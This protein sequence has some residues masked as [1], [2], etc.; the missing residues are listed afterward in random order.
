M[1]LAPGTSLGPY[2]IVDTIGAGGMGEVYRARDTRL[3]RQVAI[4]VLPDSL[5]RDPDGLARFQREAKAVAALSHANILALHDVGTEAGVTYV[6]MELLEGE[7]LRERVQHGPVPLRKAIEIGIQIARGLA[8]AH[9]KGLVH[10]DLKP[11]NVFLLSD[12]QVKVLDFGLAKTFDSSPGASN[13][14][15]RA[16]VTDPGTVLGTVGYMAPEQIRGQAIDARADLFALGAVLFEMISGKRAFHRETGAETMTAILREDP[17]E[18]TGS[19]IAQAPAV[20]RIIRHCLEKNPAER[21]QTARDVAFALEALSGSATSTTAREA[22]RDVPIDRPRSR[23]P[24]WLMAAA[25]LMVVGIV[26]A[27]LTGFVTI[28]RSRAVGSDAA[29]LRYQPVT[30]DEGFV[31]AARFARDGRTLVYSAEWENQPHDIFVTSM[32]SPDRRALGYRGADLLA[33]APDGALAILLDSTIPSGNPYFRRGTVARASLNGSAPKKELDFVVFADFD[34][35]GSLAV[36]RWSGQAGFRPRFEWP[37]GHTVFEESFVTGGGGTPLPAPR[38][39]PDGQHAAF[40]QFSAESMSVKI[41]DRSGRVVAESKS[42]ADWWGLAWRPDSKE[43][44]FAAAE[45]GGR[46]TAMF[47]LDLAGH[48]RVLYRSPTMTLHDVSRDGRVLASFDHYNTRIETQDGAQ[49]APQD[50]S[51]REGGTPVDV[52]PNGVVLFD[53]VG[54][55]GGPKGSV[56]V[57]TP[58]AAE[59]VRISDGGGIALSPDGSEALVGTDPKQLW[60]V[61]TAAGLPRKLER[62]TIAGGGRIGWLSNGRLVAEIRRTDSEPPRIY[63]M[64][65]KDGSLTQVLPD[66][67]HLRGQ[68]FGAPDATRIAAVDDQGRL[69]VCQ[70][71]ATGVGTCA[72][73]LSATPEDEVAGWSADSRSVFVY[74]R[75]PVPAKIDRID[76]TT[77]HREP[78]GE[79]HPLQA[80]VSGLERLFVLP[81]GRK[82]YSYARVRSELYVIEGIR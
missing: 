58:G 24:V 33:L 80:A 72:P 37:E 32:D 57:R 49:S 8:A 38:I 12:G 28:A 74:R 78:A 10:R 14:E 7:S 18:L 35:D 62:P 55:S 23:V 39:A 60:I 41:L 59:P 54:D 64:S 77:G 36:T 21:F 43:V 25:A 2:V 79:V 16:A 73:M 20:D 65:V 69:M 27:W 34:P 40:F 67:I 44:W 52:S 22:A 6:V 81:N 9:A 11:E 17:P 45:T 1:P 31:F 76:I 51:W 66:G 42:F 68:R 47:G 5:A 19:Q 50:L 26:A 29:D 63:A 4:K 70:L 82:V 30:F 71:P 61:P 53:Q 56:Y 15:T 3:D 75:Y 46:Q 48:L 13:A